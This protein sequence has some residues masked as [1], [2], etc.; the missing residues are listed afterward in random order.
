MAA[1]RTE[2]E[3]E[4]VKTEQTAPKEVKK[5]ASVYTAEEFAS[6]A[7]KLFGTKPDIVTA[8]FYVAGKDKA[9]VEEAKELVDKFR[10]KEVK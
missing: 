4:S 3:T 5:S 8:A 1:K 10:K 6:Q 7:K 9:T 2:A